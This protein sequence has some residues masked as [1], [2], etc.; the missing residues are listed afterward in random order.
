MKRAVILRGMDGKSL[1]VEYAE[2]IQIK[3]GVSCETYRFTNDASRDVAIV[4]VQKG[5]KTPLQKVLLGSKT[6]EGY[7]SGEG[8]LTVQSTDGEVEVY[9]YPSSANQ[10]VEVKIGE[11]MQWHANGDSDLTFYEI[12]EPSYE[13]GR[14]ENLPD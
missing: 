2:T 12:C 1:P 9:D 10:E 13:D 7:M 11:I 3:E 6:L 4:T 14:F 5:R 8:S